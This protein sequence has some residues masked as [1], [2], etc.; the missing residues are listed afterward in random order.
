MRLIA[1]ALAAA[2]TLGA[3]LSRADEPLKIR[4]AWTNIPGQM[5]P[6]V[7]DRK[8]LLKHYGTSYVVEHYYFAGSGPQVTALATG[9]IDMGP[10]APGSFG[11]SIQNAKLDDLRIVTDDYQDGAAGHYTGEYL[12]IKDSP[13]KTVDDL[14]GKVIGVNAVG[15]ASET[16]LRAMMRRHHLETGKDYSTVETGFPNLGAMLLAQ[17]IDLA[18]LVAP[19]T[20]GLHAQGAVRTLFTMRD[21]MGTTQTLVYVA[22]A[23]FLERN[24]TALYDFFE[25][26]LRGPRWFLDPASRDTVVDIIAADNKTKREVFAPYVFT[27]KDYYHNPDGMPDL[28]ALQ[29]NLATLKELGLLAIDI[30]VKQ[31]SD[32]S[33]IEEAAK[34]LK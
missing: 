29:R 11:N 4:I 21:V 14:K 9:E 30:D 26:Y 8:D 6:L 20:M 18:C 23:E 7:F 15:G 32:L 17:K 12:V 2:L 25:D 28:A 34:R 16:A 33:F 19:Y 31:H 27:D 22:R 5:T 13:I 3:P 10:L 24:R 1:L